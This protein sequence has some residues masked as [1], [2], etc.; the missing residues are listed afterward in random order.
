MLDAVLFCFVC[1]DF[2][3]WTFLHWIYL[4]TISS[5][6]SVKLPVAFITVCPVCS[7][8]IYFVFAP[9]RGH[10]LSQ[11]VPISALAMKSHHH[12]LWPATKTF[13]QHHPDNKHEYQGAH[14]CV[15]ACSWTGACLHNFTFLC[16]Y[17]L[18]SAACNLIQN[19]AFAFTKNWR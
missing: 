18:C 11:V 10:A 12:D 19:F 7:F 1:W 13:P 17:I 3:V 9:L 14:H 15:D 16:M 4:H 8:G 5:L 2:L 6:F